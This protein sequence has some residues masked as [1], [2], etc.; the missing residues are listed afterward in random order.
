MENKHISRI[1][2][3]RV[4]VGTFFRLF[5]NEKR[6]KTFISA[7]LITVMISMVT[8]EEM[9]HGFSETKS[10]AFALVSASIW[11]GIFH[12]LRL[13]CRERAILKREHRVGL[14]MSSYM[15]AQM[16]YGVFICGVESLLITVFVWIANFHWFPL[17]GVIMPGIMEYFI[18]TFLIVYASHSLGLAISA[19]VKD[20]NTAMTV[21][22][23][24]LILQLILA[25]AVFELE[26]I[27]K[28]F[29]AL[30]VSR[31]GLAAVCATANINDMTFFA[32]DDYASEP[33]HL[34]FLWFLLSVFALA[35]GI[36][37]T[38]FLEF[39]DRDKR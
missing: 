19:A 9:F 16:I 3:I 10:G 15:T 20:E 1:G 14:H 35:Y 29:S 13:V 28:W 32:V 34:L 12:S 5:C 38:I 21:M 30:T 37:G 25:G 22:P 31:W 2:Q 11:I 7:V 23:F 18:S 8:G 6:W 24:A 39:I 26:G 17:W 36:I 4:Y 27:A 33:F